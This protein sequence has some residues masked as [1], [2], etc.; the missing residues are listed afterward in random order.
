[1]TVPTLISATDSSNRSSLRLLE[2]GSPINLIKIDYMS[3][4]LDSGIIIDSL[5]YPMIFKWGWNEPVGVLRLFLGR[6]DFG[7]TTKVYNAK[8]FV[9]DALNY[10]GV[11]WGDFRIR[12]VANGTSIF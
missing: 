5:E 7:Y 3:I 9:Y 11:Y 2:Q 8:L 4:K 6:L 12:K 10:K 1:M